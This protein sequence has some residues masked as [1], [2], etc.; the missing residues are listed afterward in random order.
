MGLGW[1]VQ[2]RESSPALRLPVS[3]SSSS[4]LA[5]LVR[6]LSWDVEYV[7]GPGP[8][9]TQPDEKSFEFKEGAVTRAL[10]TCMLSSGDLH[11]VPDL[12]NPQRR[13]REGNV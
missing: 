5:W 7:V 1:R 4:V 6:A 8:G 10:L 11:R 3:R 2:L 9:G 12:A 13:S